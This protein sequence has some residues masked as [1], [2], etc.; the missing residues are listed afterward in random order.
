MSGLFIVLAGQVRVLRDG[1]ELAVLGPGEALRQLSL[2]LGT[3]HHHDR[4][5]EDCELMVL[6][7]ALRCALAGHPQLA[8]EIR[9]KAEERMA[10]N[11]GETASD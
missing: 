10:M 1:G 9:R 11:R 8:E 3:T 5:L 6:P 4:T 7:E 2:L